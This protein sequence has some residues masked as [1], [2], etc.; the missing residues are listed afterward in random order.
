MKFDAV[1]G[2]DL[3]LFPEAALAL[4]ETAAA[5]VR[6]CDGTRTV[7]AII[8]EISRAYADRGPGAIGDEVRTFLCTIRERGLLE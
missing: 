7:D 6:L 8:D 4:N 1:G 2:Q 5:V 3:L